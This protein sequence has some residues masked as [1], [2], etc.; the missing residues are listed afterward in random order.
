MCGIVGELNYNG[1]DPNTV[2]Q[3]ASTLKHRGP[4]SGGIWINNNST[5]ALA[6]RRLSILDLSDTGAQ[7]MMSNCHRFVTSFNGEIYNH[8]DLRERLNKGFKSKPWRGSSDTETLL[9]A[10][11]EWGLEKTLNEINGMFAFAIWDRKN[12]S[13]VLVRDRIGEK[14]LYYG[15]H[16]NAF[17]FSSEIR[18]F[19]V[20]C[21]FNGEIDRR[22]ISLQLSHG[23]IPAPN[24]IYKNI[25]KLLP[26]TYI[27]VKIVNNK[28]TVTSPKVYWSLNKI[29]QIGK[30]N[31]FLGGRSQAVKN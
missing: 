18:T 13:L 1:V 8:L 25:Y 20:S 21:Y 16:K 24:S 4:D 28:L 5:I 14:P 17:I 9:R 15:Q 10:W 19:K 6:H 27:I 11:Q 2:A 31:Q 29:Y 23:Y 26:G 3:M 30:K 12:K 7:P 22:S